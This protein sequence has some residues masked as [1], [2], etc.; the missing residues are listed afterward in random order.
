MK[1]WIVLCKNSINSYKHNGCQRESYNEFN[2]LR[3]SKGL[4]VDSEEFQSWIAG[5]QEF[6]YWKI[7]PVVVPNEDYNHEN[8][9]ANMKTE[10]V[11]DKKSKQPKLDESGKVKTIQVHAV[12][13][14]REKVYTCL[15]IGSKIRGYEIDLEKYITKMVRASAAMLKTLGINL[16]NDI[17]GIGIGVE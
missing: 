17:K 10:I 5:D 8:P 14:E 2:E 15:H 11:K 1:L 6:K 16:V 9:E 12:I 7:K 4:S 13:E 3:I